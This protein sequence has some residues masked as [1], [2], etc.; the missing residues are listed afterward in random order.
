MGF[1]CAVQ[2][3]VGDSLSFDP[4]AFDQSG[5]TVPEVQ[6]L[7]SVADPGVSW[8]FAMRTRPVHRA[9]DLRRRGTSAGQPSRRRRA[10]YSDLP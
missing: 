10:N 4:F 8:Y 3:E 2:Q 6:A 7:R 9:S 5:L 1:L